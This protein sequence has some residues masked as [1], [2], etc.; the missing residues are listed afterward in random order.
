MR[1]ITGDE[2]FSL[3]FPR[4]VKLYAEDHGIGDEAGEFSVCLGR[5][6]TFIDGKQGSILG[7]DNRRV[8]VPLDPSKLRLEVVKDKRIT[9]T[10]R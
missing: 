8:S 5:G 6:C 1:K 9:I 3:E 2:A 7:E 4:Q 10:V